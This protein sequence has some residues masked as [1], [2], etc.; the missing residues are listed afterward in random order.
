MK[1]LIST[2]LLLLVLS[3]C[4]VNDLS[5]ND[6]KEITDTFMMTKDAWNAGDLEKFMEGYLNSEEIAF[7]GSAGPIYG[8]DATLKR[9]QT[10][11]PDTTV[12]GKL[13]FDILKLYKI[14]RHSAILI[15]KFYLTRTIGDTWGYYTLVWQK[16]NGKWVII[17]DHSSAAA[18][19]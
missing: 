9:Y 8:Y 18:T 15:G 19:D 10:S 4:A 13:D 1:T 14:D 17:T 5:E 3:G 12:M 6:R 16:I 7:V 11:Y 2:T